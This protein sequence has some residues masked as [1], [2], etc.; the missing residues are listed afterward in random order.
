MSDKAPSVKS[1]KADLAD[2]ENQN[3]PAVRSGYSKYHKPQ[4][5]DI[6]FNLKGSIALQAM[7][8]EDF[9]KTCGEGA[10]EAY[11]SHR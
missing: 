2:R 3:R 7:L 1:G 4:G 5:H 10:I 6:L 11:L 9:K 8:H